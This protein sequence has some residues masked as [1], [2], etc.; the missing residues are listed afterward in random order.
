MSE[1]HYWL[2]P[3]DVYEKLNKEFGFTFDPCPYPKP[4]GFNSLEI[5]WGISNYCNPPFRASDGG[6]FGPTAWVKKAIEE[7]R[8]GKTIVLT[9]PVRYYVNLLMEA[10]AEYRSLGRVRWLETKTKE[11]WKCPTPTGCFIL[12]GKP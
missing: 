5:D 2:T 7:N 9:I 11:P 8:Q 4:E 6:G 12:R 3:P 1:K 10:G